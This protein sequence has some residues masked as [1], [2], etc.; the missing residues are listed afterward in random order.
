GRRVVVHRGYGG[1]KVPRVRSSDGATALGDNA[2]R[3]R[4]R[5]AK[6]VCGGRKAVC[7]NRRRGRKAWIEVQRHVRCV[8][9]ALSCTDRS[10]K[11]ADPSDGRSRTAELIFK[12]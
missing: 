8:R 1:R 12:S 5:D 7:R 6:H 4:L 3:A 10:D 11:C 2:A 9:L